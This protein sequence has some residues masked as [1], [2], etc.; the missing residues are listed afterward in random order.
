MALPEIALDSSRTNF[1]AKVTSSEIEAKHR[2]VGFQGDF[3]FD[4]RVI[5]FQN[6]PV[7]KAGIT[8]GNWNV[9][10]NVLPGDGPSGR[11]AYRL[12]R[13]TSLHWQDQERSS[14]ST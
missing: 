9:S 13:T 2:L 12:T 6:E 4:E 14:S 7:H 3:T 1:V 10:G 5:G 11:C 8:S